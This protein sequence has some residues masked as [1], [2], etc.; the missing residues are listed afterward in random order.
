MNLYDVV[1]VGAGSAG[2]SAAL[3]LGRARRKV[4]VLN[5]G[6]PR[7]APTDASHNFFTRDGTPPIEMLKIGLEQLTPYGTE[8]QSHNA[9][10]IKKTKDTFELMLDNGQRVGSRRIILATGVVDI[11]PDIPGF[12][13]LWGK[14]IHHCPYCHGWE[15]RDRPL[16][17]YARGEMG[18]HFAIMI[19]HWSKDLV[20]CSNGD[21]R[22]SDEQRQHLK[23]FDLKLIETPIQKLETSESGLEAIV[24]R[25]STALKREHIFMRPPHQQ[26]SPLAAQLGCTMSEDGLYVKVNSS[27]ETSVPGIYAAGDMTGPMQAVSSAVASGTLVGAML[28]H[29]LVFEE[30]KQV[31][32][33]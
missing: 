11:L 33:V 6:A 8:V 1:I 28:N 31:V 12:R 26:R 30:A 27:G 16:A 17:V 21:A 10:S 7:N 14:N 3:A 13:E 23:Q 22:F 15:V 19:R 25:D 20:V 18:Y 5:G 32:S 2:L 24:F 29:A 9:E 4:L